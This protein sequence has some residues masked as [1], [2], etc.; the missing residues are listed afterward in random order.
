M[1][2]TDEQLSRILSASANGRLRRWGR[3]LEDPDGTGCINQAAYPE[4]DAYPLAAWGYNRVASAF[5]DNRID[6]GHDPDELLA[7]LKRVGLA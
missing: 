2:F 7:D 5:F 1:K 4:V 6:D 3:D